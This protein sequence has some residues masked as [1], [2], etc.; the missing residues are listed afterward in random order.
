MKL[1][2]YTQ[3]NYTYSPGLD[4]ITDLGLCSLET[5]EF[6]HN[7]KLIDRWTLLLSQQDMLLKRTRPGQTKRWIV[8][9]IHR[10]RK[11]S[12][13]AR[14]HSIVRN[15]SI[16]SKICFRTLCGEFPAQQEI[17]RSLD[18]AAFSVRYAAEHSAVGSLVMESNV[19]VRII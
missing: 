11:N 7:K 14:N 6:Q 17:N 1:S 18:I 13:A 19:Y 10:K 16:F 3:C 9:S 12:N 4:K 2:R 15:C 5:K 8:G